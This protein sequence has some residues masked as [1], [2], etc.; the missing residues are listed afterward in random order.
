M[1]WIIGDDNRDRLRKPIITYTFIIINIVVFF[2]LQ[3]CGTNRAFTRSFA[4]VPAEIVSGTLQSGDQLTVLEQS[5][6][7]IYI[8]AARLRRA[9]PVYITLITSMFL[10][11]GLLHI[12]GNMLFLFVFGDNI[13]DRIGKFWYI[14]FYLACGVVAT[15]VQVISSVVTNVDIRI[16]IVGASG[17]ISG[18]LAAYVIF[19]PRKRVKILFWFLLFIRFIVRVPSIVVIGIWFA[20]Q[21]LSAYSTFG[22][23]GGGVAYAAHIGG[24]VMGGLLALIVKLTS[25]HQKDK[26]LSKMSSWPQK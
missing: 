21:L 7:A 11:G 24:F 22:E 17:A 2:A 19:Y 23:G 26:F 12:L 1:I 4:A 6:R 18:L 9:L 3:E 20:L 5:N 8:M 13:E 16:P 14:L 15:L 25:S 10:H